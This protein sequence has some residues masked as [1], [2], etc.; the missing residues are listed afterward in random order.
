MRARHSIVKYV[1]KTISAGVGS[2]DK[3]SANGSVYLRVR[4]N[5]ILLIGSIAVPAPI[6]PPSHH[7]KPQTKHHSSLI[8]N[9]KSKKWKDE[10]DKE[11]FGL[12][13][14]LKCCTYI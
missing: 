7:E 6:L 14:G 10:I 1:S 8:D 5:E 3:Q 13:N 11:S 12:D 9:K 4:D 2:R